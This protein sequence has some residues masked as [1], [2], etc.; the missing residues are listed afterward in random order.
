VKI[1]QSCKQGTQTARP[2]WDYTKSGNSSANPHVYPVPLTTTE[3]Y[4][5]TAEEC[6]QEAE[7]AS[8]PSDKAA[9][10]KLAEDWR[11]LAE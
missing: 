5:R 9:W 10:L 4:R 11:K 8:D 1:W 6:R 2:V 7:H 3:L